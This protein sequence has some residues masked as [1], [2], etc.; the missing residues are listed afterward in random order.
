MVEAHKP[1]PKTGRLLPEAGISIICL[2]ACL[3]PLG[4]LWFAWTCEPATIHWAVPIAARIPFGCGTTMVLIYGSSY[5][6]GT[7]GVYAASAMVG[8]NLMKNILGGF[9]P[10]AGPA[11]FD[12]LGPRWAGTL[13]GLLEVVLIPIPFYFYLKG[14]MIRGRSPVVAKLKE[15]LQLPARPEVGAEEP[16]RWEG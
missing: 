7:Y 8:N 12:K 16:V 15:V 14:S 5:I 4:Q 13:L 3:A 6:S 11:M 1:D 9:L 2:A 10:L